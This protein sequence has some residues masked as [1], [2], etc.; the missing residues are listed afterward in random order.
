MPRQEMH[1]D[2]GCKV[3][4]L[5][6]VEKEIGQL[7]MVIG[8]MLAKL[9]PGDRQAVIRELESWGVSESAKEFNQFANPR[10]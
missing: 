10:L 5:S 4:S 7:K 3:H 8:F 1:L 6:D 9:Q 2:I